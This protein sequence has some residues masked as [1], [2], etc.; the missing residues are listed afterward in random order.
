MCLLYTPKPRIERLA[1]SGLGVYNRH[2]YFKFRVLRA[3]SAKSVHFLA[4][5]PTKYTLRR[6]IKFVHVVLRVASS[7]R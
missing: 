1:L 2:M 7:E 5:R 3:N 4:P 6:H